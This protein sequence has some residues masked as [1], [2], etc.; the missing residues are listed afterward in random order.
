MS[1]GVFR[2]VRHVDITEDFQLCCTHTERVGGGGG[3]AVGEEKSTKRRANAKI[4][5]TELLHRKE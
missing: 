5:R 1:F 3:G 4:G 2:A